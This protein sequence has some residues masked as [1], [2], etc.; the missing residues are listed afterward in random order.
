[1][2]S[3]NGF[4]VD[5]VEDLYISNTNLIKEIVINNKMIYNN[6]INILLSESIPDNENNIK[7]RFEFLFIEGIL[8]IE[9]IQ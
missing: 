9:Y 2:P 3:T 5:L 4:P 7:N 1:M 6:F 8:K